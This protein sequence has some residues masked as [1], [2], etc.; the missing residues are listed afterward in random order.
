MMSEDIW[1]EIAAKAMSE[2]CAVNCSLEDFA[3]GCR[4]IAAEF[5]DRAVG[6]DEEIESQAGEDSE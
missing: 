4:I 2:A 5:T 1:L 6:I 3:E